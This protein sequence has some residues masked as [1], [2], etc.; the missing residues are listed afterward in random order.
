MTHVEY[1]EEIL[2]LEYGKS[3]PRHY[4]YGEGKDVSEKGVSDFKTRLENAEA[5]KIVQ[6]TAE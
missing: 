5:S 4:Q 3:G 1:E 2:R 6:G